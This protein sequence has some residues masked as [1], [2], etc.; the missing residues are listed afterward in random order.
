[1]T[2]LQACL[3]KVK[4]QILLKLSKVGGHDLTHLAT[5]CISLARIGG[6]A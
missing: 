6:A 5:W 3:P 1:M 4:R 2:S